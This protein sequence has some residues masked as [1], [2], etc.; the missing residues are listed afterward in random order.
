M[1][2]LV[3]VLVLAQPADA[4]ADTDH[5]SASKF[6]HERLD[7][8]RLSID[9]VAWVG[10][11]IDERERNTKPSALRHLDEASTSI[12][13]N[14]A[15]GNG[16]RSVVDRAPRG[17]ALESAACLD[18]LMARKQLGALDLASAKDL[19]IR[20]VS[21]LTKLIEKLLSSS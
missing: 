6:D 13:L 5:M 21:M 9:F 15:E 7:V 4:W 3:L 2:V 17:S 1:L 16:K 11:F 19:L 14:I 12:A 18:V 10:S 20:I 8:Y